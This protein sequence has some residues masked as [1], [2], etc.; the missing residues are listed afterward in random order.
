MS[1]RKAA[2]LREHLH[3]A[4]HIS[5]EISDRCAE[6]AALNGVCVCERN[7]D[8]QTETTLTG[9]IGSRAITHGFGEGG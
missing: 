1:P 7:R 9:R 2:V 8:M 3:M 6:V 5:E 4:P